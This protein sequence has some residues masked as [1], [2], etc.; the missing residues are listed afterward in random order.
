MSDPDEVV[1]ALEHVLRLLDREMEECSVEDI[2]GLLTARFIVR[3]EI[4]ERETE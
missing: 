1:K 4:E 3:M 2:H